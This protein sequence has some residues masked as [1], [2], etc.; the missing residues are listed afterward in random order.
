MKKPSQAF[1]LI[2]LI[3][4]ITILSVIFLSI[5]EIYGNILQVNKRLEIMRIVQE[6]VR[7]ITE[8][9]A[10]DVREKGIDFGY[11]DGSSADRTNNY[12]G[13]GNVFL[14]IR[15]GDKYYPMMVNNLGTTVQCTGTSTHC[16]IGKESG[17]FPSITKKRISDARVRIEN[18][19]FFLS[20]DAGA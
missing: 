6:N 18:V 1:T 9:V 5:F 3:V 14:A 19:R 11:Y 17:I 13:S 2:E 20:G 4:S 16:F 10:T 15:G 8:Q 12:T 7:S